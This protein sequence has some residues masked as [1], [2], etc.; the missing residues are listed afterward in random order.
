[1]VII[2]LFDNEIKCGNS[3]MSSSTR[4]ISA[5]STAISLPISP[6]AIP[7]FAF[8]SAGA[9]FTPSP[10]IQTASLWFWYSSI[11]FN[12]CSGK[13][14]ACTSLI[15]SCPAMWVAASWWSPVNSTGCTFNFVSSSI[16]FLLSVRMVSESI[17]YPANMRWITT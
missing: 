6:I 17:M 2:I 13:Q 5:A 1:M 7:T 8:L 9:S 12:L 11:Q 3:L 10:I 14:S 15:W 4:T 16:I